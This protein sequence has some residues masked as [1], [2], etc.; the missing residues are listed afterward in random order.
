[1]IKGLSWIHITLFILTCITTLIA[2]AMHAGVDVI[3]EP[4]RLFEGIPFSF[5]L[6]LIL[7]VHELSHYTASK[8]HKTEATLPYFIPAPPLFGT[9]GAFIK[10]K[11]PVMT[12]AAL[13]DIG[14][15]GPIMGFIVSLVVSVIGLAYSEIIPPKPDEEG[16][17]VGV[18]LLYAGLVKIMVG[19]P[20]GGN[21]VDLHPVAFAGWIGMFVTSLNL[22]P[23]GQLDGGHV[24]YALFGRAHRYASIVIVGVLVLMS[25]FW[26]GWGVWAL[27]MVILG[28]YHPP[29]SQWEERLDPGRKLIGAS[30]LLIFIITFTPMPIYYA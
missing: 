3:K 25:M 23:V 28:I 24:F 16:I 18:S 15:S 20:S 6:M 5:S 14:A 13:I 1:M 30:S 12:R 8:I 27:L 29:V 17:M 2:G 11:S 26:P 4:L 9:M 21:M 10:M 22:I 7:L 19:T